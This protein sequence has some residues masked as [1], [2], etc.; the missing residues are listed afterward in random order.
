MTDILGFGPDK[1]AHFWSLLGAPTATGC[2]EWRSTIYSVGYGKFNRTN[3]LGGYAHRIAWA[4]ANNKVP[5]PKTHV[6]HSCDNKRCCEPTHLS[7]GTAS[8]NIQDAV[9]KGL[10]P[11]GE[12]S[13]HAFLTN[14]QVVSMI[15]LYR[16][17]MKPAEI[18][19]IFGV[20]RKSA[21]RIVRG[22]RWKHLQ[23]IA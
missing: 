22:E 7:I 2:R 23:E 20:R 14:D 19:R 1:V 10:M 15:R 11:R 3:A 21:G 18:G 13:P 8:E 5:P 9:N 16:G 17:G 12:D 6:C 4:L